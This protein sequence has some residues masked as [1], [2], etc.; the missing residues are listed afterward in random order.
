VSDEKRFFF[1]DV[2]VYNTRKGRPVGSGYLMPDFYVRA[3]D[4]EKATEKVMLILGP[5]SRKAQSFKMDVRELD[6]EE[7]GS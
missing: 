4:Q 2:T 5:V 7:N 3:T 1:A 6:E